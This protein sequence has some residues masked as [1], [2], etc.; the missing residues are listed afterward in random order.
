MAEEE[1][2][3]W[4]V[5]GHRVRVV[6][7]SRAVP[8]RLWPAALVAAEILLADPRVARW[9]VLE[10]GCG[11]GLLGALPSAILRTASLTLTDRVSSA[12]ALRNRCSE[13]VA[14]AALDWA[15]PCVPAR[16]DL[17][18]MSD[19]AYDTTCAPQL[20]R[21]LQHLLAAHPCAQALW[22]EGI[23]D[24]DDD[25]VFVAALARSGL[26]VD[27]WPY[28]DGQLPARVFADR[29]R[30]RTGLDFI[31]HR[32]AVRRVRMATSLEPLH[33]NHWT[34]YRAVRLRALADAPD[35]FCA[36]LA[37]AQAMSEAE[38]RG[39]LEP[40]D[41]RVTLVAV[42]GAADVGLVATCLQDDGC[43]HVYQMWVAPE[44]RGR[45]VGRL[46]LHRAL[47]HAREWGAPA[48]LLSVFPH[49]AAAIGLYQSVGFAFIDDDDGATCRPM[50]VELR[51][52]APSDST[53]E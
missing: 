37:G 25:D 48:V 52:S 5:Q 32:I 43:A 14:V 6:S 28:C 10:L 9:H 33:P 35:A 44:A 51:V 1:V 38:W 34:R 13:R 41:R 40:S 12:L 26:V 36:S 21:C 15:A 27:D 29:R 7:D 50:R 20:A 46:L 39:R 23:R 4:T 17:V 45:G 16:L 8:T 49:N 47:S 24:Q 42:D 19:V 18:V 30:C 11:V 31:D 3:E 2:V 53:Q 22:V